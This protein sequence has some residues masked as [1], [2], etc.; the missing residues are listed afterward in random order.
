MCKGVIFGLYC[1]RNEH[2]DDVL[3]WAPDFPAETAA[4]AVATWRDG[5]NKKTAAKAHPRRQR[6]FPPDFVK[7]FVPEWEDFID[8]T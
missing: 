7:E 4:H 6:V 5:G 8:K 2:G 3:Q 1:V